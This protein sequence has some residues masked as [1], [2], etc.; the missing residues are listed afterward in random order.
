MCVCVVCVLCGVIKGTGITKRYHFKTKRENL[1]SFT[2]TLT[3]NFYNK[4]IIL[5][6]KTDLKARS[7]GKV[8][9][10]A[11]CICPDSRT[12]CLSHPIDLVNVATV[13]HSF[14]Y[15]KGNFKLGVSDNSWVL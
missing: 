10:K 12:G 7:T 3:N 5:R 9:V 13:W 8:I 2:V 15:S 4:V 14:L 11:Q 6:L 1:F